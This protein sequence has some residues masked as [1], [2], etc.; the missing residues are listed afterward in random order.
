M[1][2]NRIITFR[3]SIRQEFELN[4]VC[5]ELN[6]SRSALLRFIIEDFINKYEKA[7]D[8]EQLG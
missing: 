3:P 1:N 7:K 6:I 8:N 5:K 2:K 4:N